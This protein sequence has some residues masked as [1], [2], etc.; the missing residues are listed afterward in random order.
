MAEADG[1]TGLLEVCGQRLSRFLHDAE[2]KHLAWLREVEEQGLR[3][4]DSNF[5]A[6]PR[7]M[8][9]TPSQRRRPKKR[10]SSCLKDENKEPNRRR[11]SRR[12]SSI[13]PSSQ[14]RHSKEQP[15]NPSCQGEEVPVPDGAARPPDSVKTELPALTGKWPAEARGPVA[16]TDPCWPDGKGRG[17]DPQEKSKYLHSQGC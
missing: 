8:P 9:K 7:L 17:G 12:R 16:E 15:Q 4:L 11:L 13:K 1:P 14:R 3:M 5:G 6:E 10:P 2:H